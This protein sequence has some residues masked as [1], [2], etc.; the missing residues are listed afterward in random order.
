[1]STF[2]PDEHRAIEA[3]S[4]LL[5]LFP[6]ETDE[7]DETLAQ[8]MATWGIQQ[9]PDVRRGAIVYATRA[10]ITGLRYPHHFGELTIV[11]M[12]ALQRYNVR[13]R[14]R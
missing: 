12:E 13:T 1:M 9:G 14:K 8:R 6:R 7:D 10:M 3:I 2:A 4:A 5:D 11:G